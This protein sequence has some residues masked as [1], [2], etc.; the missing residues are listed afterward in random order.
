MIGEGVA[1]ARDMSN[2]RVVKEPIH[3]YV[4]VSDLESALLNDPLFQRLHHITQNGTAYLTYPSNRTS[5]LIHSLGAMHVGGLMLTSALSKTDTKTREAL[6]SS[7]ELVIRRAE[8]DLS[9]SST[10]LRS[11]LETCNDLLYRHYGFNP[12]VP[13]GVTE[14]VLFQSVRIACVLHDV[15]H[16][17]L[18]HTTETVLSSKLLSADPHVDISEEFSSFQSAL[19]GLRSD[20]LGSAQQLHENIGTSLVQHIFSEIAG[21]QRDFGQLCFWIAN[22]IASEGLS[23]Q[24]PN[25][26]FDC[27]HSIM[28][29]KGFDADR[30]DY[31]LRDG[32]ASSFEFGEYDLI[33]ILDN[34]RFIYRNKRLKLVATTTAASALESFFLERYRIYRWLVFHHSVVRGEVSASR[35]L[36]ILLD[37]YFEEGN[38]GTDAE[39]KTLL[40]QWGFNRLWAPFSNG[41]DIRDYAS[42]DEPWLHSLFHRIRSILGNRPA[43]RHLAMLKVYLDFLLTRAQTGFVTLWKRAEEYE[44]FSKH[45]FDS[46]DKA[47]NGLTKQKRGQLVSIQ[48]R[49][50][51]SAT[52]WFN[53][54]IMR[55]L[56]NGW[57]T[58]EIEAM[59]AAEDSIQKSLGVSGALLLK[60]LRFSSDVECDLID[61]ARSLV[62]IQS[63]SSIIE[64]MPSTWNKDIQLRAYWVSLKKKGTGFILNPTRRPPSKEQIGKAFLRGILG[65]T[66]FDHLLRLEELQGS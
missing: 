44:R 20:E 39:I 42:C 50:N 47:V 17:P 6:N 66:S 32:Y 46:F 22:R 8:A 60:V 23:N 40:G 57:A 64:N 29:S 63:L 52:E 31:V 12:T 3:N 26:V 56:R 53:R 1:V 65:G 37:I 10:K 28:S 11:Y 51:E 34:L 55:F 49:T 59:R 21:E 36:T 13:S 4:Y 35:A 43:P 27:L 5:R 2:L 48:R 58:G 33:R 45:V 15:G 38:T 19:L 14:I 16:L 61:K 62:R 25:K 18:S 7:F 24:N 54:V 9:L 41:G 30:G